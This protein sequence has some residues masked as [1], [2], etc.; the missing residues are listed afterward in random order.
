MHDLL[1]IYATHNLIQIM[2]EA[3]YTFILKH[4]LVPR[5]Q[6]LY[7][8]SNMKCC[9]I[10]Y[11]PFFS[12]SKYLQNIGQDLNHQAGSFHSTKGSRVFLGGNQEDLSLLR[13][14]ESRL[15]VSN[16]ELQRLDS[17]FTREAAASPL[18]HGP[19]Y[20]RSLR[21]CGQQGLPLK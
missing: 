15:L 17:A 18:S 3:F 21:D 9:C 1:R 8:S 2:L 6:T 16:S 13:S 7:S 20:L 5:F 12:T 10:Y 11:K 14:I 19:S 4:S